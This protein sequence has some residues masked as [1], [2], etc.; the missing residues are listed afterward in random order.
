MLRYNTNPHDIYLLFIDNNMIVK[1]SLDLQYH[2]LLRSSFIIIQTGIN[3]YRV[4]K[5]R[6]IDILPITKKITFDEVTS[7]II[8]IQKYLDARPVTC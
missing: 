1:K 4:S 2:D 3:E 8:A 6:N 7:L 5:S